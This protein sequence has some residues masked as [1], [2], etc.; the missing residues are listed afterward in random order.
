VATNSD[1]SIIGVTNTLNPEFGVRWMHATSYPLL[2]DAPGLHVENIGF[3]A[4]GATY[5]IY[6]RNDGASYVKRGSD[7]TTFYNCHIKGAALYVASGGTGLAIRK[8]QFQTAY[9]GS[10]G[11]YGN[12]YYTCSAN[13]GRRFTVAE[14]VFQP[15]LYHTPVSTYI[16]ILPPCTQIDIDRCSFE[17]IPD[18]TY[19][20]NADSGTSGDGTNLGIMRG[21]WFG[22]ADITPGTDWK[23]GGIIDAGNFDSTNAMIA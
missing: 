11:G 17:I 15:G 4:E 21:C 3:F 19:F 13:P 14:C 23:L 5:A 1:I 6:L 10:T 16:T 8:C 20:I 22:K 12:I 18:S 2:S 7:G 9:D